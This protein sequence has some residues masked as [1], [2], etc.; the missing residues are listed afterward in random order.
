M[1]SGLKR[2]I[3]LKIFNDVLKDEIRKM[4]KTSKTTVLGILTILAALSHAGIALLNGGNLDWTTLLPAL[5]AGIGL[6]KAQDSA[7]ATR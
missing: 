5:T 6:I 3:A 1:F 4:S 7:P 2:A